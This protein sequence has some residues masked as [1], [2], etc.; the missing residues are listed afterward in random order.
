VAELEALVLAFGG[1]LL[2]VVLVVAA[3][4]IVMEL[5]LLASAMLPVT[6]V[7]VIASSGQPLAPVLVRKMMQFAFVAHML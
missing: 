1:T 6:I 4:A 7:A 5:V 3:T 2:V